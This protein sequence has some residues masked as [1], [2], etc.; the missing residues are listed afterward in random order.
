M[1]D[2]IAFLVYYQKNNIYS[3][4][5]LIAAIET[6]KDLDD[7]NIYFTRGEE[8]LKSKLKEVIPHH[9]KVVVGISFF[10]TQLWEIERLAK[11]LKKEFNQ[12]IFMIAGGPHPTGDPL[13]TLNLGFDLVVI[14][15]GEETLIEVLRSIKQD[16]NLYFIKGIG[17]LDEQNEYKYSGKRPPIN[18]DEYPPLPIKNSRFGAIE[19]TRGCPHVCYFCQT[20]YIFG[21]KPRHRSIDSICNAVKIMALKYGK[22]DIRFITPNAFSYGSSDGKSL[23]LE[24]LEE[25]LIQIQKIIQPDGKI[26]FGSFPSEVR[27]DNVQSQTLDLISKYAT[28]DNIVIGD[29]SGSQKILDLCHRGHTVEDIYNAVE[30]TLQ[31]NIKANVDFIFGLPQEEEEDVD[32]TIKVMKDLLIK[33]ARIHAHTFIPL[34]QTAFSKMNVNTLNNKYKSFMSE[35]NPRGLAYGDWKKQEEVALKISKY[36]NSNKISYF[37]SE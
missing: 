5:A 15:E 24:K 10:T 11:S 19:I 9:K 26:F 22:K 4:N 14:G 28:N 29:K 13:G 23:K 18:L 16:K 35:Y 8:N 20:P 30:L 32:L 21:G 17:F 34:P 2:E 3:F 37:D 12:E 1:V 27:P 6:Q 25:L 33:G 31:R 7:I 36:L